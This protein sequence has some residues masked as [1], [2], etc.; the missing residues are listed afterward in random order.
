MLDVG[1]VFRKGEILRFQ[2]PRRS[3]SFRMRRSRSRR[4]QLLII[5][6]VA[7]IAGVAS[8]AASSFGDL[9]LLRDLAE[10]RDE[11]ELHLPFLAEGI[12]LAVRGEFAFHFAIGIGELR[13]LDAN[14]SS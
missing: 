7:G 5:I 14:R 11:L 1:R 10:R 13:R 9:K 8:L 12:L 6:D 3:S 2:V 4:P